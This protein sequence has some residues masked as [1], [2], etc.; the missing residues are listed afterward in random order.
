MY[1]RLIRTKAKKIILS[2]YPQNIDSASFDTTEFPSSY[3]CQTPYTILSKTLF[4]LYLPLFDFSN[5]FNRLNL[6]LPDYNKTEK[7]IGKFL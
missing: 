1:R 3:I 2:I 5:L 7:L 6:S 4:C